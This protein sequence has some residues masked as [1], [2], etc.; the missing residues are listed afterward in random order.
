MENG[1]N[2]TELIRV[3]AENHYKLMMAMAD[4]IESLEREVAELASSDTS[5]QAHE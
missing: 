2:I 5:E 4:H 1:A 3:T